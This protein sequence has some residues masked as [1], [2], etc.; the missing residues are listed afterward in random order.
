MKDREHR[1]EI[2]SFQPPYPLFSNDTIDSLSC[3]CLEWNGKNRAARHYSSS[4]LDVPVPAYKG[5]GVAIAW[6]IEPCDDA[7]VLICVILPLR[8]QNRGGAEDIRP[9]LVWGGWRANGRSFFCPYGVGRPGKVGQLSPGVHDELGRR[10][11]DT[12]AFCFGQATWMDDA[13]SDCPICWSLAAAGAVYSSKVCKSGSFLFV[14]V[15]KRWP[16]LSLDSSSRM[17]G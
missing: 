13:T 3:P 16:M 8:S 4:M 15:A 10:P 9:C 2:E 6:G 14:K 7:I 11:R 1:Q 12:G 17:P 5:K